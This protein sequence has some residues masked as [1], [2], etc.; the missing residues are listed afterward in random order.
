[1]IEINITMNTSIKP[2]TYLAIHKST[3]YFYYG[4]RL[5]N[6]LPAKQD[7][8]IL[9]YTSS[10]TVKSIIEAEGVDSFNWIIRKE[11]DDKKQAVFWEYKVIRRLL[12][13]PKILNKAISP[14][15]IPGNWFTNGENNIL[16]KY[17]P[18]G[19]HPGRTYIE[20]ENH[21][22]QYQKQ[23]QRKWYNNGKVSIHVDIWPGPNW[24]KGRL[25]ADLKNW[26]GKSLKNKLWWNNGKENFRGVTPPDN[27]WIKGRLHFHHKV[28]RNPHSEDRKKA[29]SEKI[30][31]RKWYNNGTIEILSHSQVDGYEIGRLPAI[32][33][34]I[35]KTKQL[36]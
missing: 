19:Y 29:Q 32:G 7:L 31:G 8:S 17:C 13:H 10:N 33:N 24:I 4:V 15:N 36:H 28:I 26:N 21:K 35:S 12:K 9:Y 5:S 25:P 27:T 20:T 22:I 16:G 30:K 2:Y 34:K 14:I 1:M 6:K 18:I 23:R 3:G 11:F